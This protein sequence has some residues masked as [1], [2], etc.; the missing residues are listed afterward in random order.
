MKTMSQIAIV[1]CLIYSCMLIFATTSTLPS[2]NPEAEETTTQEQ[3][4]DQDQEMQGEARS[5]TTTVS[6]A[7]VLKII[8]QRNLSRCV[9][10]LICELSCNQDIYGP[11]G[12]EVYENFKGFQNTTIQDPDVDQF[13]MAKKLGDRYHP[14][15]TCGL[16]DGDFP[17]CTTPHK[18]MIQMATQ[19]HVV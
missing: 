17:N 11:E 12:K 4:P 7:T 5:A 16:C 8:K 19:L 6:V 10:Q 18:A 1:V 9:C 3:E 2:C 13:R 15:R 14:G